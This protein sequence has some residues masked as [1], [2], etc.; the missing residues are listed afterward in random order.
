MTTV[1]KLHGGYYIAIPAKLT[2]AQILEARKN[3]AFTTS[4]EL[5]DSYKYHKSKGSQLTFLEFVYVAACNLFD[6]RNYNL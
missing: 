6:D 5:F 1:Q 4:S 3:F 2:Q